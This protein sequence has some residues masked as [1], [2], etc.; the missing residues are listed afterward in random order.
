VFA[1]GPGN[2]TQVTNHT[3]YGNVIVIEMNNG[4]I[5]ADMHL[6][7]TGVTVGSTVNAGQQI[8]TSGNTGTFTTGGHDHFTVWNNSDSVPNFGSGELITTR[9]TVNPI[10]YLP[11][12]PVCLLFSHRFL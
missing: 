7:S 1:T 9:E 4:L 8:G 5:T 2:V 12:R 6:N 3:N 10:D 11:E